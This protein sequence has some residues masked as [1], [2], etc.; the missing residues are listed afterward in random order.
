MLVAETEIVPGK[1]DTAT[2]LC[3]SKALASSGIVWSSKFEAPDVGKTLVD[4]ATALGSSEHP[5][6]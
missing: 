2:H 6:W 4:W 1:M 3:L 5:P